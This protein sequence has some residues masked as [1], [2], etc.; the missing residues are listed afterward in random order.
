MNTTIRFLASS[1]LSLLGNSVAAVALPLIL[2]V[3]TGDPLAAGSL[4]LV[5]AIPQFI[6]G[7]VGGTLLD[8]FNRRNVSLVSDVVSALAIAALPLVDMTVG[9]SLG[10]F[11]AFGLLGAIGDIPGMTARDTLLPSVVARDKGDLQQIMG[12]TQSLDALV[13]IIGPAIAAFLIGTI[14]SVPCLWITAGFSVA[15]SLVTATIPLSVGAIQRT[16]VKETANLSS[17]PTEEDVTIVSLASGKGKPTVL[18]LSTLAKHTL[19]SLKEGVRILLKSDRILTTATLLSFGIIMILGSLQGMVLPVFFTQAG[20]PELLGYTLSTLSAGL[21]VGSLTYA[22]LVSKIQRRTW[23]LIS[24]I[25][26]AVSIALLGMLPS[27]P[28]MIASAFFLGITAGPASALLGFFIL[29]RIPEGRRGSALGT[30][31]SLLLIAAPV[32]LFAT[33]IV[34]STIGLTQASIALALC[35][36]ALTAFAVTTKSMKGINEIN[37]GV[38][39]ETECPHDCQDVE[40]ISPSE[41]C[42]PS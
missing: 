40:P 31:N 7:M 30:Q 8:R 38:L 24:F 22:A 14:G 20:T 17:F 18:N 3:T 28:L 12:L 16:Y 25:G 10:W 23:Y 41:K 4:A 34:V 32:A 26:M 29:D 15:A 5:C 33:S 6:I 37:D 27:Y 19:F 1:A 36:L 2:L 39:P 35:W 21:L 13:T 9:L 42:S 11:V